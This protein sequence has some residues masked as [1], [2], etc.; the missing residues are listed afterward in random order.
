ML[1][2][3]GNTRNSKHFGLLMYSSVVFSPKT[4]KLSTSIRSKVNIDFKQILANDKAALDQ[5][6]AM[7]SQVFQKKIHKETTTRQQQRVSPA[8]CLHGHCFL[9]LVFRWASS[10]GPTRTAPPWRR[11]SSDH[12]PPQKLRTSA[13]SSSTAENSPVHQTLCILN[14][15][16]SAD[17]KKVEAAAPVGT[18]MGPADHWSSSRQHAT[19]QALVLLES[20]R[21][22]GSV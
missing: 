18:M 1:K 4:H 5:D 21:E 16:Q 3:A 10:R 15:N 20:H 14:R 12:R 22:E 2:S 9:L 8:V 11:P 19:Q 7:M 6:T 17:G 13:A